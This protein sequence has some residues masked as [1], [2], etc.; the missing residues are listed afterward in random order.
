MSRGGL[1]FVAMAGAVVGYMLYS[2]LSEDVGRAVHV[3]EQVAR[4]DVTR[5]ATSVVDRTGARLGGLLDRLT[6]QSV[7]APAR[8]V[9]PQPPPP[10][11][12]PAAPPVSVE[13]QQAAPSRA[14]GAQRGAAGAI[15]LLVDA[16]DS[17]RPFPCHVTVGGAA[18][19]VTRGPDGRLAIE[20]GQP[21]RPPTASGPTSCPRLRR[22]R[23]SAVA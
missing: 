3:S 7:P 23:S 18:P 5:R 12:A 16:G 19:V 20:F 22:A 10:A 11:P 1:V 13:A 8:P 14:Q 15:R 4:G 21:R 2:Q 9:A 6:S 17:I